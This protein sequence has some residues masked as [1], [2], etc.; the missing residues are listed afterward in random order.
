MNNCAVTP[1][2]VSNDP[3]NLFPGSTTSGGTVRI[4]SG[5]QSENMT[6][7]TRSSASPD[8]F[9]FTSAKSF[10]RGYNQGSLISFSYS[11]SG[12]ALY[13]EN[14]PTNHTEAMSA[15]FLNNL[16]VG[17]DNTLLA[18]LGLMTFTTNSSGTTNQI[19]IR[20]QISSTAPNSPP[21]APSYQDIWRS[22]TQSCLRRGRYPHGPG[23][24]Q[25]ADLLQHGVQ[26][27]PGMPAELRR[28]GH[29]R[30]GHE[31]GG[32]PGRQPG[33]DLAR[34]IIAGDLSTPT[35]SLAGAKRV[36]SRGTT[37][38][39]RRLRTCLQTI[40]PSSSSRSASGSAIPRRTRPSNGRC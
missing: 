26:L 9:Y 8:R 34:T 7:A 11:V 13:P 23:P 5:G 25:R 31:R 1:S 10:S 14:Y 28:P 17:D 19:N 35:G 39:S 38:S 6:Y 16:S 3:W 30:R 33:T 27:Q 36:R 40:P 24:A 2:S 37:R 15:D 29:G 18:R 21:F 20:N 4:G 32:F 22:V 12:S